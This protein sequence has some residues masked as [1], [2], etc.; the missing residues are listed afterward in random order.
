VA[1]SEIG[2][3]LDAVGSVAGWADDAEITVEANPSTVDAE[4]FQDLRRLDINRLSIG[5]QSF[6]DDELR[7][8]GR[9][10]TSEEAIRAFRAARQARFD[11]VNLDLIFALPGQTET[12]WRS[13]LDRI[14]ALG[15]EHISV[16]NLTVES[17]TEFGRLHRSGQLATLPEEAQAAMYGI[18]VDRL[19]GAGYRHYEIS[20]F[21]RPGLHSRHNLG[22][23]D[24]S[25]YLGVGLSAHSFVSGR[26]AWN[27]R[28]LT[29]YIERIER[30]GT[31]VAGEETP[32]AS[33]RRSEA[34]LLG[35]RR[36]EEGV[37]VASLLNDLDARRRLDRLTVGGLLE[38]IDGRIRLTRRGLMVADAVVVELMGT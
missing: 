6:D 25:D 38:R 12:L 28:G 17:G 26:R 23:W 34:I 35:L 3:I 15:P 16:Y 37:P 4:K 32:S 29:E 8:L 2:R 20:N 11:N 13:H 10:H 21:A 22:Y 9:A 1:A 36:V 5:L 33:E 14:V 30:D 19:T 27:V 18:A 24:G 31:A 7:L